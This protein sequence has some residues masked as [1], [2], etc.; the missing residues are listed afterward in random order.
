MYKY[1]MASGGI[2]FIPSFVEVHQ[3]VRKLLSRGH[4]HMERLQACI[5]IKYEEALQ[6]KFFCILLQE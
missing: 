1:V 2:T 3:M 5:S 6:I 4:T